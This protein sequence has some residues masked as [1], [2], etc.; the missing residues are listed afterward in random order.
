MC[1]YFFYMQEVMK[2]TKSHANTM[3][4]NTETE[5]NKETES[6]TEM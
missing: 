5:E 1:V 6:N 4:I 3:Q 2:H